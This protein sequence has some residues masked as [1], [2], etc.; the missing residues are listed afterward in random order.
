MKFSLGSTGA[1]H[2]NSGIGGIF[3]ALA[4]GDLV[5]RQAEQVAG[6]VI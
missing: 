6:L 3:K 5:R 2:I 4:Q 1:N